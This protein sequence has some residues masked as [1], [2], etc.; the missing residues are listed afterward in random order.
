MS[1]ALPRSTAFEPFADCDRILLAVSGGPD[2][3]ALLHLAREWSAGSSTSIAAATVDH[4]LRPEAAA[5]SAKVADWCRSLGVAHYAL[6]WSGEKPRT[7]LHETARAA[8]YELLFSLARDLGAEA[9][10]TAHHADDQAETVLFRLLRGSGLTGLAAMAPVTWRSGLRLGRPLLDRTKAEL[11]AICEDRK[12]PFFEDP[13]NGDPRYARSRLRRLM[14]LLAA[15]GLRPE[16]LTRLAVRAA[17]VEE[18]LC[19]A[20]EQVFAKLS[21]RRDMAAFTCDL[22]PIRGEPEEYLLRLLLREVGRISCSTLRLERAER[23]A[24]GLHCALREGSSHAGTLGGIL[25]RLDPAGFLALAREPERRRGL[26]RSNP[27]HVDV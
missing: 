8:R 22:T 15:E 6:Q 25:V 14:P 7:R 24:S 3:M 27:L 13:S 19:H 18:A 23:L 1:E 16:D 5:E 17:R 2:S 12:Q 26:S 11:V 9:V 21:P 4:G 20:A 10:L